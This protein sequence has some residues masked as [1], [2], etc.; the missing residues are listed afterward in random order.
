MRATHIGV[1][2]MLSAFGLIASDIYLPAMPAMADDLAVPD[3][4]MPV[5]VS[6]YLFALAAAQ[7]GCGPLS[8]RYGRKP[9]LVAGILIYIAASIGCA[10]ATGL[11]ML[12][13]W[14]MVQAIG[15]A[16]GLVIGRAIIADVCDK[17]G[18]AHVYAIIYPLVSLSP[19][20]APVVGGHL[21]AAWGWRVDFLFVALFGAVTLVMVLLLLPETHPQSRRHGK[22][23]AL[24]GFGAVLRN[25]SF[26]RYALIVCAIY[27]AWFVYLTQSPFLFERA[28]WSEA[29]SGW[30]YLPLSACIIGANM[31]SKAL[32]GRIPYDRIN[33]AGI[34]CFV[35][36][37]LCFITMVTLN[38]QGVW[39]VV[40]PMCLVSLANGSSLSLSVSGAIAADPVRSATAS[41]LIG[42]FQ[43]GSAGLV[44]LLVS[45]T[46][47]ATPLVLG[48]SVLILGLVA[49]AT[50]AFNR[51]P[52]GPNCGGPADGTKCAPSYAAIASSAQRARSGR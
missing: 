46:F 2:A 22:G 51:E 40:L 18:S 37:G 8:D 50:L 7:L 17:T 5:T 31:L 30:L 14:R 26:N 6:V 29:D 15:A 25:A 39:A 21:A 24:A 48:C 20:L 33:A 1:V 35:V 45:I 32:L 47:G 16:S 52:A 41:G 12:L 10:T 42:F 13:V 9:M 36:G 49:A 23:A 43:V 27:C 19:A 3:Q 34:A 11:G 4:L 38:V 44:A 28:G